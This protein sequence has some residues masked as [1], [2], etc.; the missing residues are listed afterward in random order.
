VSQT[1]TALNHQINDTEA[2]HILIYHILP[3]HNDMD[4]LCQEDD[5]WRVAEEHFSV[6]KYANILPVLPL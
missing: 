4:A 5:W 3:F 2:F 6:D 1:Q